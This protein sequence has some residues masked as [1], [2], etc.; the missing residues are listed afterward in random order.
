VLNRWRVAVAVVAGLVLVAAGLVWWRQTHT[1]EL[2][3]AVDLAPPDSQRLSWTDWAGIRS[4]LHADLSASSSTDRL[5]AF[6]DRGYDADLTSTSA[7]LE[8]AT[9]LHERFGFS[10]ASLDWELFAQSEA[11]ASIVLHLPDSADFDEIADS[12]EEL[13]YERPDDED[14]VWEGG[15]DLLSEIAPELTP[16]LQ[17]VALDADDHLVRTS[18]NAAF[19]ERTVEGDDEGQEDGVDDVVGA[20]GHP[21]SASIYTGDQVC[22]ALAMSDADPGDQEQADELLESAGEVNPMTGFGM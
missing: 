15:P 12:L 8:S 6:L 11:G 21:L 4:E 20:S 14:G 9:V 19:L 18:D 1:T 7:L 22:R 10:P 5:S 2:E 3:R 13:G 16:E 17:Y